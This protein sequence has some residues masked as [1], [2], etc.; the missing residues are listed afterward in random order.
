LYEIT[1]PS[2][3][4]VLPPSGRFW[5]CSQET[6]AK[7]VSENRIWFGKNGDG[8]PRKKTF[9]SEVQ[10]GLRPNTILFQDEVGNN[11]EAKQELKDIFGGLGNFDGPKPVRLI[12]FLLNISNNK[13]ATVLDFFAGSGTTL[14][15]TMQLNAK[16]G[17]TRKCILVTN[18]ENDI[19]KN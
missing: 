7:W 5:S 4:K 19:C 16:D 9:L 18:N 10:S 2:G 8:S 17:G 6:F 3:R 11:Q 15:A 12:E 13:S 1:T 14:H